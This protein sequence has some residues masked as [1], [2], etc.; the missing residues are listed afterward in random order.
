MY[1]LAGV[2][3]WRRFAETAASIG[4]RAGGDRVLLKPMRRVGPSGNISFQQLQEP[5]VQLDDVSPGSLGRALRRLS[6]LREMESV[7]D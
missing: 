4:V 2:R 3:S 6:K 5:D 7:A 1:E